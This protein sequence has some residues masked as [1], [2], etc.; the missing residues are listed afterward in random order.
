[1]KH[2]SPIK[3]DEN[4]TGPIKTLHNRQQSDHS[5]SSNK[6]YLM[7]T[8]VRSK[9]QFETQKTRA[10]MATCRLQWSRTI[11]TDRRISWKIVRL[12]QRGS[13]TSKHEGPNRIAIRGKRHSR[14]AGP[15]K[16][17]LEQIVTKPTG[18]NSIRMLHS[19][20][21]G[22][23]KDTCGSNRSI[24]ETMTTV[25]NMLGET[26]RYNVI[27][28]GKTSNNEQD[29]HTSKSKHEDMQT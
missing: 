7:S 3:I 25:S 24:N 28:P 17:Q 4:H 8:R 5:R 15:I 9:T 27:E 13:I 23:R 10:E 18:M 11:R 14:E 26:F 2:T 1:M 29:I 21:I 19:K 12:G 16:S 6:S 20:Q 22:P